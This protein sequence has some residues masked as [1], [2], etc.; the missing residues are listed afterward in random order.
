MGNLSGE[1]G[2]RVRERERE[3]FTKFSA[4]GP[5]LFSQ[6][7]IKDGVITT[8]HFANV[9]AARAVTGCNLVQKPEVGR[10]LAD[11]STERKSRGNVVTRHALDLVPFTNHRQGALPLSLQSE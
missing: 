9:R 8:A 11:A 2:G 3:R 6:S 4:A 5:L 1:G 7:I 10:V